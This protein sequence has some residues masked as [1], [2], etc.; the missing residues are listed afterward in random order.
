LGS[1]KYDVNSQFP[2]TVFNLKQF[3]LTSEEIVC[4]LT[5]MAEIG[6]MELVKA[7]PVSER[8]GG[9]KTKRR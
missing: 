3:L 7:L 4:F 9:S 6:E 8:A 5:Q 2:Q 1:F